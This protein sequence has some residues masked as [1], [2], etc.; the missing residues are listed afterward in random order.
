MMRIHEDSTMTSKPVG[1]LRVALFRALRR[2]VIPGV[3]LVAGHF[4]GAHAAAPACVTAGK[5]PSVQVL[6]AE[7]VASG[8]TMLTWSGS[9]LKIAQVRTVTGE[10]QASVTGFAGADLLFKGN[11][12]APVDAGGAL[13][14]ARA[15][16]RLPT[17]PDE[18]GHT[19]SDAGFGEFIT[20]TR[21][22]VKSS[23]Q[24]TTDYFVGAWRKGTTYTVAV[25]ARNPQGILSP[26]AALMRSQFPVRGISYAAGAQPTE[27]VLGVTQ[28]A[29][30]E[31]RLISVD[32]THQ[33]FTR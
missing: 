23:P 12:A 4:A 18:E 6:P 29:P 15:A 7:A 19:H 8:L 27:G 16:P 1:L 3:L 5:V 20:G 21:I 24:G 32:W 14:A 22:A 13:Q 25:F 28:E 26:A 17:Q 31:L 30:G 33:D 10:C 9:Q 2:Q 11:L